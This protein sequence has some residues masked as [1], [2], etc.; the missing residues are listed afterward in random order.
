MATKV[1]AHQETSFIVKQASTPVASHLNLEQRQ[2]Q[3]LRQPTFSDNPTV[4][5]T[6]SGQPF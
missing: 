1:H 2:A 6:L 4:D 3:V 5:F